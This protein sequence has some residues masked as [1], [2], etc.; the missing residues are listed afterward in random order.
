MCGI[1]GVASRT[2][3]TEREPLTRGRDAFCHRGPDAAG[4]WWSE[5]SRVGLAHRRLA[6]S[7]LSERGHQPMADTRDDYRIVFNGEIYNFEAVRATLEARG[8]VFRSRS[9]TEVVLEA[10]REWGTDCLSRLHGMFALALFDRTTRTLFLARDRAG[11]KPLFYRRTAERLTFASELK[12]LLL[13]DPTVSRTITPRAFEEYLAFGYV[14]GAECIFEGVQK[15]PPAH[16]AT[17]QV[18]DGAWHMWRWWSLPEPAAERAPA[19]P[20]DALTDELETLLSESVRRQLVADVP[21]G[22]LLSGGLDSS[23]VAA[24][25]ARTSAR[26]RTFNIAFPGSGSFDE[27]PYARQVAAQDPPMLLVVERVAEPA[28]VELLPLLAAQYDEPLADSSMV[29]TYLVSR[30][31]REHATVA[32]GGDGG[33]ELF[34]GYP[35]YSWLLRQRDLRVPGSRPFRAVASAAASRLALGTR[36]RNQLLALGGDIGDAIAHVNMYF[37]RRS[38][39]LL[40]PLVDRRGDR[41]ESVRARATAPTL[42]ALQRAT[43]TDFVTYLPDDILVKVDR[44]SMLTSLEVR[45]PFLDVGLVDFAFGRVP[46]PLRATTTDRKI[47]LRRLGARLLPPSLDLRRKQG[48]MLPLHQWFAGPWGSYLESVLRDAPPELFRPAAITALFD[49]QRKGRNNVQRIY[50]LAMFELWRREYAV[51]IPR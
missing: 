26:V 32:L 9:D 13:A 48:F 11:E 10:Y 14:T 42:S 45:A 15:L 1:I 20:V 16:A 46:D 24:I 22:V 49:G 47:L 44:A 8:H 6:I 43:R 30:L 41:V 18:D 25:A 27:S 36:G 21:V 28:T 2:P 3:V 31:I 4:A 51:G 37:D 23:I 5:D 39:A 33:D 29:P 50:A 12:G 40:S 17:F 19:V 7:D 34:G 35:H 38:R